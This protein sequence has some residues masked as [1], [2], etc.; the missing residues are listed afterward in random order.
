MLLVYG[1]RFVVGTSEVL[2]DLSLPR[3]EGPGPGLAPD[4][5]GLGIISLLIAF[6]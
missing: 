2:L 6:V 4:V 1:E 5:E 3:L